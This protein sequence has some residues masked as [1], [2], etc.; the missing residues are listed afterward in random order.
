M[1]LTSK[2]SLV[3]EAFSQLYPGKE[4]NF[5]ASINY[6][7]RFKPYNANLRKT[8]NK[9]TLDLSSSW[10]DVDRNI[11][12]GLV[13]ELLIR[14]LKD[15]KSTMQ[16]DLY[17]NF[18]RSLHIAIPKT[19]AEPALQ[20]SFQR[21]ND[22]YFSGLIEMPNLKWGADSRAKLASYD[23][24]TDTITVSTLFRNNANI[25]DYLIYHELLHKKM[26]YTS[27]NGRNMH[28]T[29]NFKRAEAAFEGQQEM[30]A[31][32]RRILKTKN[33]KYKPFFFGLR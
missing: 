24:H 30:E 26:K 31:E 4:F 22:K 8:G 7:A 33:L 11:V 25:V 23:Y 5:D 10:K 2:M 9:L 16:I 12:I 13:Q 21:V 14:I 32:I 28:H 3:L 1:R 18:I 17:N 27:R 20:E 29:A 6:S 15:K 19:E